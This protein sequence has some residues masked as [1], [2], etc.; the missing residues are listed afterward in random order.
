MYRSNSPHTEQSEQR[1]LAQN[2]S[3]MKKY[4]HKL[5]E[6]QKYTIIFHNLLILYDTRLA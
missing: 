3:K 1:L 4:G 2:D 5:P 6:Y